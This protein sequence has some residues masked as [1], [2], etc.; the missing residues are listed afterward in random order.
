MS[1]LLLFGLLLSCPLVPG[2]L[3]SCFFWSLR[4]MFTLVLSRRAC[5][6][7]SFFSCPT[8]AP[9]FLVLSCYL[10]GSCPVSSCLA[11]S[12]LLWSCPLWSCPGGLWETLGSLFGAG[13]SWGLWQPPGAD[14]GPLDGPCSPWAAPGP[15]P[16]RLLSSPG[17]PGRPPGPLLAA[18]GPLLG[19]PGAL[20]AAP[21]RPLGPFWRLLSGS[22]SSLGGSKVALCRKAR[23]RRQYG[24]FRGFLGLRELTWRL[25]RPSWGS[26]GGPWGPPGGSWVA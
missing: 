23:I 24:V 25:L 20:L 2:L 26:L 15:V 19:R 10:V 17:R 6:L 3:L 4:V 18:L 21:G 1:D 14:F 9:S 13:T 22:W 5:L 7:L 11:S 16:G 8:S 12:R